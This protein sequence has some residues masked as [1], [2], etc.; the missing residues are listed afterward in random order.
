MPIVIAHGQPKSGSTFLYTAGTILTEMTNNVEFHSFAKSVGGPDFKT[1]QAEVSADYLENLARRVPANKT[2]I[3]KTHGWMT[4]DV[5]ALIDGHHFKAFTS[6]RDPRDSALS[7]LNMGAKERA[8]GDTRWFSKME[9]MEQLKNSIRNQ[10]KKTRGWIN[11]PKVLTIPYYLIA[12]AEHSSVK[13]IANLMGAHRFGPLAAATMADR[14]EATPEFNKGIQDRFV[15]ELSLA[16]LKLTQELWAKEIAE[17]EELSITIMTR[18]GHSM[19]YQSFSQM[20]DKAIRKRL[21]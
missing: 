8:R 18:L 20:R 11:H 5:A 13:A 15:A 10:W 19:L 4:D 3:F 14:R 16:D 17:Y 9:N 7:I 12:G 21:E 6:F 1:F 2:L